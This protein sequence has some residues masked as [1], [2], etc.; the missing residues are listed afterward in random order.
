MHRI[1]LDAEHLG[2]NCRYTF[3]DYLSIGEHDGCVSTDSM[4]EEAMKAIFEEDKPCH[5]C[6]DDIGCGVWVACMGANSKISYEGKL[7]LCGTRLPCRFPQFR[8]SKRHPG[9]FRWVLF[10][11]WPLTDPITQQRC[12]LVCEQNIT[13]VG[14]P[15]CVADCS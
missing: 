8:A 13:Q 6:H 2:C 4:Y 10:E 5:R 12:A 7:K 3:K 9:K 14:R 11:M 1:L 15:L